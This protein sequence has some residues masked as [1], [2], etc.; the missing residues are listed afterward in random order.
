MSVA[1]LENIKNDGD[2]KVRFPSTTMQLPA[3]QAQDSTGIVVPIF[4]SNTAWFPDT[5]LVTRACVDGMRDSLDGCVRIDLW[6]KIL[7]R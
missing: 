3:T 6:R 7:D 2:R 1:W 5:V 4:S